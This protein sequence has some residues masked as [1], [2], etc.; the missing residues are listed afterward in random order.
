LDDNDLKN[1]KDEISSLM[2]KM[3]CLIIVGSIIPYGYISDIM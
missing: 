2:I 3:D 1:I